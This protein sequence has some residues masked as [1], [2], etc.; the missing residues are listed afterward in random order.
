MAEVQVDFPLEP[1]EFQVFAFAAAPLAVFPLP[2]GRWRVF[3]P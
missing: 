2:S 1:D 3:L